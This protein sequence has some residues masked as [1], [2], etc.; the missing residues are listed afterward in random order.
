MIWYFAIASFPMFLSLCIKNC[1]NNVRN[2][3]IYLTICGLIVF[4]FLALRN[5]SLGSTDTVNYYTYFD[6]AIDCKS[7][8]QFYSYEGAKSIGLLGFKSTEFGFQFFVFAL[9][10]I[11]KDPQWI[12]V[13]SAAICVFSYVHFI[14][15]NSDNPSLSM[16]MFICLG[17]MQFEMQAM[18]QVIAMSICLFSF[19]LVKKRKLI[20]FVL[21]IFL[22]SQFHQTAIVF[23]I[24][25]LFNYLKMSIK[26]ILLTA[27]ISLVLLLF[28]SPLV[29]FANDYFGMNYYNSVE[30]GGYIA[31]AIYI[32]TV[33][34]LLV[35]SKKPYKEHVDPRLFYMLIIGFVFYLIR[36]TGA[37]AS[38][39]ISYYFMFSQTILL[40]NVISKGNLIQ[41]EKAIMNGVVFML[42]VLLFMYRLLGS[43][44]L[45]YRF[46][47]G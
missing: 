3:K 20:L 38:E 46:F 1:N 37:Q 21:L 10:R 40:P 34:F 32:L 25:Y 13:F 29:K 33:V 2:K 8:S 24:V 18:R 23:G 41:K 27:L 39:R 12:I 45:P 36:Y 42:S 9:S 30:R 16:T 7:W 44:F 26:S 31:T 28:S 5:K 4:L 15:K 17:L 47:W 14:Y 22:A 11:F 43:N 35:F 6:Y 19:E